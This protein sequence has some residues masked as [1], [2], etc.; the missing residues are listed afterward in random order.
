MSSTIRTSLLSLCL[1]LLTAGC[2]ALPPGKR[3]PRDPWERVN[4]ATYRFND[5]FDRAIARPVARGYRAATLPRSGPADRQR[6][7]RLRLPPQCLPAAPRLQGERRTVRERGGAGAQAHGGGGRGS[8]GAPG[9][10]AA[11]IA[12][13]IAAVVAAGAAAAA[14]FPAP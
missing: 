11:V 7:R 2:A 9:R 14:I 6:L 13:V 1:L 5:K 12:A 10:A 3:D 8:A 4:R